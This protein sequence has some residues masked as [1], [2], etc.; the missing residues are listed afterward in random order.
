MHNPLNKKPG[1]SEKLGSSTD[2]SNEQVDFISYKRRP[3]CQPT[4]TMPTLTSPTLTS[5]Y[6]GEELDA[7]VNP[8][9]AVSHTH[10]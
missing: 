10:A 6:T 9:P 4:F 7:G 2:S 3:F 5:V 1:R 8:L